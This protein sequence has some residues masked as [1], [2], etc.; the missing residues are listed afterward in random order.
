MEANNTSGKIYNVSEYG[1]L[2]NLLKEQEAEFQ[3]IDAEKSIQNKK[4][5]QY[6]LVLTG[7]VV[8]LYVFSVLVNKKK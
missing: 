5:L 2:K 3:K 6:V 4:I 7:A 1:T 8:S